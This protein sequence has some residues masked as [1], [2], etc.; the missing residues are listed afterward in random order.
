MKRMILAVIAAALSVPAVAADLPTKAPYAAPAFSTVDPFTGFYIGAHIGYGFDLG[1]VTVNPN[2]LTVANSPQGFV[3][4]LHLGYGS[5]LAGNFY[6]GLEG[7]VDDANVT[8]TAAMPGTLSLTTGNNWLASLRARFG[9]I[10]PG[11]VL[12]Y[13]TAGYGWGGGTFTF[14]G[15]G[16]ALSATNPTQGGFAWG[17]GLEFPLINNNWLMR[18]EYLQYDF[19]PFNLPVP[20]AGG[21]SASDQVQVLR[22]G[23]TYKF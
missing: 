2:L 14:A 10:T 6:L 15:P 17:G 12:L 19:Q 21:T 9:L 13:G 23:L 4:G 20:V 1:D 5:R 22:A 16:G 7:D 18:L 11:N 8:G 3:G